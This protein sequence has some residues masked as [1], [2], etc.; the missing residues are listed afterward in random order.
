ME[1]SF[2]M[3]HIDEHSVAIESAPEQVWE[4]VRRVLRG[5]FGG[6]GAVARLL[7]CEPATGTERFDGRVGDALPGFRV[8]RA[9]AHTLALEG[10]HRF[11]RYRL[12]F[13][14]GD[15]VLRAR[16]DADFPGL[17][18]RLYRAAVIGSGGHR[19]VTRRLLGQVARQP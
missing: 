6:Q 14:L 3:D 18:G 16:T 10:S 1:R 19:I 17:R 13:L 4:G 7:G 11:S 15:G 5:A 12:T 9:D 8:V 2:Y